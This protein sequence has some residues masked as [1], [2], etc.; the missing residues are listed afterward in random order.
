MEF[1]FREVVLVRYCFRRP[2]SRSLRGALS[3]RA[4]CRAGRSVPTVVRAALARCSPRFPLRRP[5]HIAAS[6]TAPNIS[7]AGAPKHSHVTPYGYITGFADADG[8]VHARGRGGLQHVLPAREICVRRRFYR[9]RR[10]DG[11]FTYDVEKMLQPVESAGAA[12]LRELESCWPVA[13]KQ[14]AV[15]AEFLG[16]QYLRG[17]AFRAWHTEFA[18]AHQ[19][20]F[21][22]ELSRRGSPGDRILAEAR[23]R[24]IA[25]ELAANSNQLTRMLSI[26]GLAATAFAHMHW[27][28]LRFPEPWLLSCD[29]P[30]VLWPGDVPSTDPRAFPFGTG[31]TSTLELRFPISPTLALLATWRDDAKDIVVEGDVAIAGKLN[32]F[33]RAARRCAL[34]PPARHRAAN[35]KR[36]SVAAV[37]DGISGGSLMDSG[38]SLVAPPP[39]GRRDAR[40]GRP[41]AYAATHNHRPCRIAGARGNSFGLHPHPARASTPGLAVALAAL[42]STG[43]GE[44]PGL[45]GAEPLVI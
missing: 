34:V 11:S 45:L 43:V 33:T 4:V 27:T 26:S 38:A 2:G 31:V 1:S 8:L 13:A 19:G 28:L 23:G 41:A 44:S 17:P 18:H 5:E 16:I 25:G 32:A 21:A 36:P 6:P 10:P 42:P 24:A 39:S 9:R 40:H 14:R 37:T 12:L 20:M 22:Q 29:H 35:S 3:G 30:V 7:K 15:L